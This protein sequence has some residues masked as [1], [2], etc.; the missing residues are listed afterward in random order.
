M[1]QSDPAAGRRY[2]ARQP[3]PRSAAPHRTCL[4]IRRWRSAGNQNTMAQTI[5]LHHTTS[6][7]QKSKI[8]SSIQQAL[9]CWQVFVF[10]VS[11]VLRISCCH[12]VYLVYIFPKF[13]PHL[14]E[15]IFWRPLPLPPQQSWINHRI[16]LTLHCT[17]NYI[18]FICTNF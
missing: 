1:P 15:I 10:C 18:M 9:I 7:K 11:I 8:C 16:R 5:E 17:T 4:V 14:T 13:R 2:L 6:S 12:Y 3:R